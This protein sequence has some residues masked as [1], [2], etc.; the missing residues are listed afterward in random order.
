MIV[1]FWS[2]EFTGT[3]TTVERIRTL[4]GEPMRAPIA[5]EHEVSVEFIY[6]HRDRDQGGVFRHPALPL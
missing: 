4:H 6:W 3:D 2:A 1:G 5:G